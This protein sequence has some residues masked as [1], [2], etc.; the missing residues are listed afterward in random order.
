ML[1]FRSYFYSG[2]P[3]RSGYP[4]GL[5]VGRDQ[6]LDSIQRPKFF[7]RWSVSSPSAS[8]L[9][10][11]TWTKTSPVSNTRLVATLKRPTQPRQPLEP[12]KP[13]PPVVKILM[14]PERQ[15][16]TSQSI[17]TLPS[18]N[19]SQAPLPPAVSEDRSEAE[20]FVLVV[21]EEDF[22]PTRRDNPKSKT[23]T[24]VPSTGFRPELMVQLPT[25]VVHEPMWWDSWTDVH[26][27]GSTY[28]TMLDVPEVNWRGR[29]DVEDLD[30]FYPK[31]RRSTELIMRKL[32]HLESNTTTHRCAIRKGR[33]YHRPGCP[34]LKA[35]K[36]QSPASPTS[37]SSTLESAIQPTSPSPHSIIYEEEL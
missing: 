33:V 26:H 10:F 24:S 37:P 8:S 23:T 32:R 20:S 12:L 36:V 19:P 27:P 1:H 25:I 7:Q 16:A 4:P 3:L 6:K 34:H 22:P 5:F 9:T 15:A 18:Q 17:P 28:G 14:N 21:L 2:L 13:L 30:R 29:M 31:K 11:L 35:E